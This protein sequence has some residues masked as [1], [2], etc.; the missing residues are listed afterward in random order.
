VA[1]SVDLVQST[2]PGLRP[3]ALA[4]AFPYQ[5]ASSAITIFYGRV[6]AY[7]HADQVLAHVIVHEVTHMLQGVARHSESGVMKAAWTQEDYRAMGNS[8]LP[9]TSVDIH[10]LHTGF[11]KRMPSGCGKISLSTSASIQ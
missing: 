2:P 10:L 9:L 7:P 11:M 6:R 5:G 8:P 3:E 4:Y 1:L